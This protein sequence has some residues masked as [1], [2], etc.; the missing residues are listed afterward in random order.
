LAV[1]RQLL[2]AGKCGGTVLHKMASLLYFN[3]VN[4]LLPGWDGRRHWRLGTGRYL[5]VRL[6]NKLQP[7]SLWPRCSWGLLIFTFSRRV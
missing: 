4:V 2:L 6:S 1:I 7:V 5:A 3:A